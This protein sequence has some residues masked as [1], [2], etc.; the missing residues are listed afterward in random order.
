VL[1]DEQPLADVGVRETV[2]GETGDL[3]LLRGEFIAG[4][5]TA[6]ADLLA[7]GQQLA[8]GAG[9]ER[10]DLHRTEQLERGAQLSPGIPAAPVTS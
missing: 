9:G 3:S 4:L 1:A 10:L 6:F 5:D 2:A 7:G 8:L